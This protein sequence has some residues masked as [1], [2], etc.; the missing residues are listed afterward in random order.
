MDYRFVAEIEEPEQLAQSASH[1]D[2]LAENPF[3]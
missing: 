1:S 2:A 3:G